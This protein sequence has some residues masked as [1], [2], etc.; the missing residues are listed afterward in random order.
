MCIT[1]SHDSRRR[2]ARAGLRQQAAGSLSARSMTLKLGCKA[3]TEKLAALAQAAGATTGCRAYGRCG[4]GA[5]RLN[6]EAERR[7][8]F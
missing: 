4:P 6:G 7:G 2:K 1:A 5:S 3:W 8:T